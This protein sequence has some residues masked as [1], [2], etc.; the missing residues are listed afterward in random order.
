MSY[1]EYRSW[2]QYY[3]RYPWGCDVE[4]DRFAKLINVTLAVNTVG[5]YK[6][7]P[8]SQIFP[9]CE[10]DEAPLVQEKSAEALFFEIENSM[11]DYNAR[12]KARDGL[13]AIED[14]STP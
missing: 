12:L 9:R 6:F 3:I 13:T 2:E 4:D 14:Q 8:T 5:D 7:R 11:L 1:N 10:E